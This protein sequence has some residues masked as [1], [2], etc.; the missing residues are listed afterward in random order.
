MIQYSSNPGDCVVD[1]FLGSGTTVCVAIE[2]G[3]KAMGF[4]LNPKA[5]DWAQRA[6]VEIVI[7][8]RGS[9]NET[10]EDQDEDENE[11]EYKTSCYQLHMKEFLRIKSIVN[12][13]TNWKGIAPVSAIIDMKRTKFC[14]IIPLR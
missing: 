6:A 12:L 2:E 4:E 1:F 9:G 10:T 14:L 7:A 3:R 11:D 8:Q 13:D 5:F